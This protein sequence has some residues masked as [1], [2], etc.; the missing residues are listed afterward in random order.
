MKKDFETWMRQNDRKKQST[1]Y[2]YARALDRISAHY[3][4]K[5]GR[6][7][8]LKKTR[9]P[10]EVQPI[11]DDYAIG[12]RFSKFGGE[13]NGTN[14]NAIA[15]YVRYLRDQRSRASLPETSTE[16]AAE[17]E[18]EIENE[19]SEGLEEPLLVEQFDFSGTFTYERDLQ[20]SLIAEIPR[21]FEGYSIYGEGME[22][23]EYS[24][25]GK[26]IDVLLEQ[27]DGN[28]LLAIELKAGIADFR[29]FGQMSMYLGLLAKDFP[30]RE[31]KGVI[32]ASE[33]DDSLRSACSITDRV[34]L[35][36]YKMRL[37]LED[38]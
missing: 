23:I 24:I 37:E 12:G 31:I 11:C 2:Q 20:T 29:V 1:A 10:D 8:D 22:G 35:K 25:D 38:A 30:G 13:G 9:N 28:G 7:I 15:A 18:N 6:L 4:Q 32:I 19:I 33:I 26:R 27:S 3:S 16:T 34:S 5:T 14:R 17:S 21:I 36:T